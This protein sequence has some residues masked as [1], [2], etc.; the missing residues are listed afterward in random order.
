[1]EPP[2]LSALRNKN[3]SS[4]RAMLMSPSAVPNAARQGNQNVTEAV[5]TAPDVRCSPR[6]APSVARTPKYPSNHA[7]TGLFTVAIAIVKSDLVSN[8]GV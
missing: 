5:T 7:V 2:S 1:M 8:T 6:Y 4:P 3:F